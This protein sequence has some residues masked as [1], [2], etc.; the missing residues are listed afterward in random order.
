M[1]AVYPAFFALYPTLEKRRRIRALEY[2]NGVR[3]A[4]LW[5]AYLLFDTIFVFIVSIICTVLLSK[6]YPFFGLWYIFFIMFLYGIGAILVAYIISTVSSSQPAAFALSLLAMILMFV[7]SLVTLL[8][9]SVEHCYQT[10]KPNS[11]F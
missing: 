6:Q 3:A 11:P 5:L 10:R 4:P 1:Q 2:S 9:S 7:L 8:V